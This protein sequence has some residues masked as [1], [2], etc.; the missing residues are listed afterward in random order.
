MKIFVIAVRQ[1]GS[2]CG[3]RGHAFPSPSQGCCNFFRA[4]CS[5]R[6]LPRRPQTCVAPANDVGCEAN[7]WRERYLNGCFPLSGEWKCAF[8]VPSITVG[9]V[10]VERAPCRTYVVGCRST[11]S[12][13]ARPV[14]SVRTG[15]STEPR[16]RA[17]VLSKAVCFFFN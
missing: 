5:G 17:A 10:L 4:N 6:L 15:V 2:C 14:K 16:Q 12:R 7:T 8:Q 9:R 3:K 13:S 11:G 1:R